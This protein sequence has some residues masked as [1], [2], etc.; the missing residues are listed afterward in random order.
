MDWL[1]PILYYFYILEHTDQI[2]QAEVDLRSFLIINGILITAYALFQSWQLPE[3]D[4][5]WGIASGMADA[6]EINGSGTFRP[7]GTMNETGVLAFWVATLIVLSLHFRTVVSL[8]LLPAQALLLLLTNDRSVSVG[9]LVCVVIA[10]LIG[11]ARVSRGLLTVGIAAIVLVVAFGSL[12]PAT[13]RHL[14]DRYT[15][16]GR[17]QEDDSAHVRSEIWRSTPELIDNHPWGLGIGALGRGA[18][19]SNNADLVSVDFG[20][21]AVYLSLGW[22]F[23]TLHLSGLFLTVALSLW[24]AQRGKNPAAVACAAAALGMLLQIFILNVIGLSGAIMWVFAGFAVT[25]SER[26][27]LGEEALSITTEGLAGEPLL[28]SSGGSGE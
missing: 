15:S 28:S 26:R 17:L 5:A 10:S 9:A 27:V 3:W 18:V 20:L 25:F 13:V 14:T 6:R 11:G 8:L 22:I 19:V 23:G 1:A 7:F 21:L 12:N 4:S 16:F 2:G 24:R